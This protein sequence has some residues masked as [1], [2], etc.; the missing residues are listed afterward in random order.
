MIV[1]MTM[2]VFSIPLY[3]LIIVVYGV[4]FFGSVRTEPNFKVFHIGYPIIHIVVVFF[5]KTFLPVAVLTS[6]IMCYMF[7]CVVPD[8]DIGMMWMLMS[9]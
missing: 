1:M 7:L 3:L 4:F 5:V 2:V 6:L 8:I 9:F